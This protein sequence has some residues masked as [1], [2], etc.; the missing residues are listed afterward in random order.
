MRYSDIKLEFISRYS[1]TINAGKGKISI[2]R[3]EWNDFNK[4]FTVFI[5]NH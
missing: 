4:L 2:K 3:W 1:H 5:V